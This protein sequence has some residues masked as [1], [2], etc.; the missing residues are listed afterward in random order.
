M[1]SSLSRYHFICNILLI[2]ICILQLS[3]AKETHN[4]TNNESNKETNKETQVNVH[5]SLPP[6]ERLKEALQ[7]SVSYLSNR[8]LLKSTKEKS[9][10]RESII[11]EDEQ[12][13]IKEENMIDKVLNFMTIH[14]NK[15]TCILILILS[16]SYISLI[17]AVYFLYILYFVYE[18]L[19]FL[20]FL[21]F[22]L[23]N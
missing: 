14:I 15:I 21:G 23:I 9:N 17:S 1:I 22:S 13:E 4:E 18:I 3:V 7:A 6:K 10:R 20:L 2:I 5:E 8:S 19:L 11:G 16:S 12:E